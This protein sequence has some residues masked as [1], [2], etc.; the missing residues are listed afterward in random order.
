MTWHHHTW[1]ASET[2]LPQFSFGAESYI[3]TPHMVM[4]DN[5]QVSF[6]SQKVIYIFLV[7]YQCTLDTD[8]GHPRGVICYIG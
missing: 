1:W 8:T 2:T 7:G 4:N 3:V 6:M 5:T